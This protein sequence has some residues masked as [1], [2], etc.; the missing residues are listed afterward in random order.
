MRPLRLEM[1][2]FGPYSKEVILDFAIL[3]N[4][5]MFLITGP[6]GAGKTSILDAIVYALYGQTSGGLRDGSDMRSDYADATTPTSVVFEFQVGD[7]RYRM[8][9]TPKQELQKK[10]GTGTRVVLATAAI[11]EWID[12][13]WK[14]LT[15]KA[16][17]IRD[18]IQQI[19]G[20]RVDQF[21]QVV[22]LPQG[23]FRK[24]LVAP[25]SEREVLLHTIF[26]TSVYKRMQDVL[27]EEL[28]KSTVGIQ[29]TLQKVEFLLSTYTV[30]TLQDL[31]ALLEEERKC[32]IE[33][34]GERKEKQH[35]YESLQ[36]TYVKHENYTNLLARKE[37]YSKALASHKEREKE[38]IALGET[39][40]RWERLEK[41]RIPLNQYEKLQGAF[42][43]N[44]EK[45]DILKTSLQSVAVL[46]QSLDCKYDQLEMQA[47][48]YAKQQEQYHQLQALQQEVERHG[49]L[50]EK[51][52][53]LDM[54]LS[55]KVQQQGEVQET[56]ATSQTNIEI[57]RQ[58][59]GEINLKLQSYTSLG[60]E[61]LCT[62]EL[63]SWWDSLKGVVDKLCSAWE[64]QTVYSKQ[65]EEERQV[66]KTREGLYH[67][68]EQ[69]LRQH[70]A[71]EVSLQVEDDAPCP[72]CG[73]LEH[74]QLA[75]APSEE[76]VR[77]TVERLREEFQASQTQVATIE[78]KLA[79]SD[80]EVERYSKEWNRLCET[81]PKVTV[82]VQRKSILQLGNILDRA[83]Q[84]KEI[85]T[86]AERLSWWDA[87]VTETH[88]DKTF[89]LIQQELVQ[90]EARKLA[91]E[92]SLETQKQ[93]I[94][95]EEANI[96]AKQLELRTLE[97]QLESLQQEIQHVTSE[98]SR[99]ETSIAPF[100]V[101]TY[102]AEVKDLADS[103]K[104]YEI[105]RK[106][107]E[108]GRQASQEQKVALTAEVG[109]LKEQQ[110]R[111]SQDIEFLE[112]EIGKVLAAE[113][114]T[115][116]T[117]KQ[118]SHAF[119]ELPVWKETFSAYHNESLR[120]TSLLEGVQQDLVSYATVPEEIPKESV[121]SLQQELKNLGEVIGTLKSQVTAKEKTIQEIAKLEGATKEL[122]DR[123]A[124][125]FGLADLAN[126]GDSGMKGVSFERYV[127][128]AILEEV[129]SAANL[130]LHDM[131]RGRYRLER[132][133]E[134]GGRGAR[135][136][137]ISV[138]DAY[139]GASRPAN[140]LSGG[141]TFLASLGLAMGLADVIQSYAGGIHLDTMFID[142]GFGTLDPDTLDVAMETLVALQSQGRLVGIISHVPEL[143]QQI[144]AHLVVTKTDEGSRAYFQVQ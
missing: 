111:M 107:V 98:M 23:D 101:E 129:L 59:L 20:F 57:Q 141:E 61:K 50:L 58:S 6:T 102:T 21:L 16:Q 15:T 37:Q 112:K 117:F 144:G 122:S 85:E 64:T 17:E 82:G 100:T 19:I 54:D 28:T 75:Q 92:K 56:L 9:R 97:G 89:K 94:Q 139:T 109:A 87:N 74:P 43:T 137:D 26:K 38:H 77:E 108:D 99:I 22:L 3:A 53:A 29:D 131:S 113:S 39:I 142:E 30:D 71:Y 46:L 118:E 63:R 48:T 13:E 78:T 134:E 104:R 49:E 55:Q 93:T 25:T 34:E 121:E 5:S 125:I 84:A 62:S 72:V 27:K 96:H 90:G 115:I 133:V 126:G 91:L 68:N 80:E 65:L 24:L 73:S 42:N 136:L 127:L 105:D 33:R 11:S 138:F 123:R 2:A 51:R 7:H 130:R 76:I 110:D 40:D 88:V 66:C 83:V 86:V 124:F 70:Q 103:L 119:D 36:A 120:L 44:K 95:T 81:Y 47:D 79:H 69:L 1:T 135:G 31:V 10:R 106:K 4:Q 14:L 41:I 128:G 12:D 143:Q 18:Y 52:T 67:H 32:L 116:D 132:S 114:L 35:Q 45:L 60:E 8:E 140:T